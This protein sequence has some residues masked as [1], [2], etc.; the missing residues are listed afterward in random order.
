MHFESERAQLLQVI[1][2]IV[3][4]ALVLGTWGNVSVRVEPELFLITPSA[5]DYALMKPEDLVLVDLNGNTLAGKWKPSSETSVHA[6]IYRSQLEA[7]AILHVHSLYASMF[8][9]AQQVI[10][11]ILEE[12]AQVI[13]HEIEPLP[14]A[15]CGTQE[16]AE[17]VTHG[18]KGKRAILLANHGLI[19]IGKDLDDSLRIAIITEKTAQVAVGA[20]QIGNIHRLAPEE[21]LRLRNGYLQYIK[22]REY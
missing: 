22:T 13:G 19:T 2:T 10:P 16:L 20:A 1:H 18:A 9:V 8:A 4:Q 14:Y 17:I 11:V 3:D 6:G 5:R 15:A 12:T 21:T 7:G